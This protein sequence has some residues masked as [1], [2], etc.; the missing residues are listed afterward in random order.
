MDR[1]I[2]GWRNVLIAGIGLLMVCSIMQVSA[3]AAMSDTISVSFTIDPINEI[4][5]AGT[6]VTLTVNA[7]VAGSQPTQVSQSTTYSISTNCTANSKKLTAVINSAMPSGIT[8]SL[9][10]TAPTGAS[11][12]GTTTITNVA[13]DVVTGI[14]AVAQS[15]IAMTFYLNATAAAGVVSAAS[16]T[17]TFT[18]VDA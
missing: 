7:A 5:I 17:L 4:N 16:K 13:A 3:Y 12:T 1:L 15:D 6:S 14:D 2:L 8:L 11:S 18:L 10:V 9:N